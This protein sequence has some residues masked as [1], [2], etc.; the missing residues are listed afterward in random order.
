[1]LPLDLASA[2]GSAICSKESLP[3][4]A[5]ALLPPFSAAMLCAGE[6]STASLGFGDVAAVCLLSPLCGVAGGPEGDDGTVAEA[7]SDAVLGS[8]FLE[9]SGGETW[10]GSAWQSASPNVAGDL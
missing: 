8:A 4:T 3:F 2:S 6:A 5:A 1:M 9:M 10:V 7:D